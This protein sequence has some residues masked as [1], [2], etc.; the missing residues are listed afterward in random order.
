MTF[1]ANGIE[2]FFLIVCLEGVNYHV[3]HM[4]LP[5]KSSNGV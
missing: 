2:Q 3:T 4:V 5:M 1:A